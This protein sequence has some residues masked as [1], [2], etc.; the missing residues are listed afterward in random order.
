MA[1]VAPGQ[2][3]CPGTARRRGS[4]FHPPVTSAGDGGAAWH[5]DRAVPSIARGR[6]T[7]HS[8]N[9]SRFSARTTSAATITVAVKQTL[10]RLSAIRFLWPTQCCS[11]I[12]P[13]LPWWGGWCRWQAAGRAISS[14]SQRAS[15]PSTGSR[16]STRRLS[17]SATPVAQAGADGDLACVPTW[18]D[19]APDLPGLTVARNSSSDFVRQ[20]GVVRAR[21][22]VLGL[23]CLA[24]QWPF[25]RNAKMMSH[26]TA[27]SGDGAQSR[28][29]NQWR[30][31]DLD[32]LL[33]NRIPGPRRRA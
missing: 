22:A 27:S 8:P 31:D 9:S 33:T 20:V 16:T 6:L 21:L 14:S 26:S 17:R 24:V 15:T 2:P 7:T 3:C 18:L 30:A 23:R 28:R 10:H 11:A 25:M 4:R 5:L 19:V 29:G 1:A 12:R 13:V 32:L